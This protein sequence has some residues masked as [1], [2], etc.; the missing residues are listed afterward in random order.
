MSKYEAPTWAD[1]DGVHFDY[2]GQLIKLVR[3]KEAK[4]VL[5][6]GHWG[7]VLRWPLKRATMSIHKREGDTGDTWEEEEGEGGRERGVEAP[8]GSHIQLWHLDFITTQIKTHFHLTT[9]NCIL[10][11]NGHL[12]V[13]VLF[14]STTSADHIHMSTS[15]LF[16]HFKYNKLPDVSV[17]FFCVW[18]R[19]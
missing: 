9:D 3:V 4:G 2:V 5:W 8:A 15:E 11:F 7:E 6:F 17:S 13:T 19:Q 1:R 12:F 18:V 10:D 14:C 16:L